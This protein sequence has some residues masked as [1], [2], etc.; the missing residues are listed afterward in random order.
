MTPSLTLFSPL[1]SHSDPHLIR[2]PAPHSHPLPDSMTTQPARN[3]GSSGS[4][5]VLWMGDVSTEQFLSL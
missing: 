1:L 5:T 2:R 4:G 3:S